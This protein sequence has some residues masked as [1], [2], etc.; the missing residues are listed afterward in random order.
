MHAWFMTDYPHTDKSVLG[1]SIKD[2]QDILY[3]IT[4]TL[5]GII[6][7][8]KRTSGWSLG[9]VKNETDSIIV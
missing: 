2:M 5:K 1:S 7:H 8:K 3:N 9:N 4:F 6:I